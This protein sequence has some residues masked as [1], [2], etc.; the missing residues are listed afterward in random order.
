VHDLGEFEQFRILTALLAV[1]ALPIQSLRVLRQG[2]ELYAPQLEAISVAQHSVLLEAYIFDRGVCAD[3]LIDALCGRARNG[4][5]VRVIVDAIGSLPSSR[6][7]FDKLRADGGRIHFYHPLRW[8]RL[9]R[10]N[11]RTHR[12]LLVIDGRTGFIG[13]AGVADH[14]CRT[15]PP[16]WRDCAVQVTGPVVAGLQA[17]FAE[18]WLECAGELL[19][20]PDSFPDALP[21]DQGAAK[22]MLDGLSESLRVDE[23]DDESSERE[24]AKEEFIR[25]CRGRLPAAPSHRKAG[26]KATKRAK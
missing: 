24:A 26:K 13:G 25:L 2:A 23:P 1:P 18:N 6:G 3:A 22:S 15:D 4:V 19:V 10:L 14:W 11:N 20:G 21:L 8:H 5:E 9:R 7:Y 12:N 16:P 17:V